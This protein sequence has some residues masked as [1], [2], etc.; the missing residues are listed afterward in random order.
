MKTIVAL[1]LTLFILLQLRNKN[2]NK[3]IRKRA[4]INCSIF[5]SLQLSTSQF[6]PN[7]PKFASAVLVLEFVIAVVKMLSKKLKIL[8]W[9]F[10]TSWI[11]LRTFWKAV[12]MFTELRA[13][14]SKNSKSTKYCSVNWKLN[15]FEKI[16]S[17]AAYISASWVE[18]ERKC[19]RSHLFPVNIITILESAW[20]LNSVN[21]FSTSAKVS[22]KL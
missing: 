6:Q 18:T 11:T 5:L 21:H 13:E 14:V 12:S 22:S 1:V 16:P 10:F 17:F 9:N 7:F 4:R 8:K 3:V 19:W 15:H 20:S 2:H